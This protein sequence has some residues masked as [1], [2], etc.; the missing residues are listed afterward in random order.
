MWH[1]CVVSLYNKAP[2]VLAI[3]L[4]EKFHVIADLGDVTINPLGT[5][6]Y[7]YP[8]DLKGIMGKL[9]VEV[10][11]HGD[12]T[13]YINVSHAGERF[14][15][16]ASAVHLDQSRHLGPFLCHKDTAVWSSLGIKATV[17]LSL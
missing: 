14:G 1:P 9:R 6:F 10:T 11:P 12:G 5:W 16:G 13:M 17:P 4:K 7:I 15:V 3:K 2:R 8:L